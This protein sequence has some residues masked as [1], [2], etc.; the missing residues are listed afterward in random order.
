MRLARFLSQTRETH[1][2]VGEIKTYTSVQI[3]TKL[4]PG[5]EQNLTAKLEL[6]AMLCLLHEALKFHS[7]KKNGGSKERS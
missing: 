2:A 1:S 6:H 7:G 3:K 5:S 4:F